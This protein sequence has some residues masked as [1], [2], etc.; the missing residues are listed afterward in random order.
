M[1]TLGKLTSHV[2][3]WCLNICLAK[4]YEQS[5]SMLMTIQR[6]IRLDPVSLFKT[7]L[8]VLQTSVCLK[9]SH[10]SRSNALHDALPSLSAHTTV[11][12]FVLLS[13]ILQLFVMHL[14]LSFS[15]YMFLI[16]LSFIHMCVQDLPLYR[17]GSQQ[18]L[19]Q[20]NFLFGE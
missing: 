4:T 7:Q 8:T 9:S 3:S 6:M 13:F 2:W 14:F 10:P 15:N 12:I 1:E 18:V 17:V 20:L 16:S 11:V 19:V 5:N